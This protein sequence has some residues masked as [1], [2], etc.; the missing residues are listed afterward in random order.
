M[1][2]NESL[3]LVKIGLTMLD[4][5]G[6]VPWEAFLDNYMVVPRYLLLKAKKKGK[7]TQSLDNWLEGIEPVKPLLDFCHQEHERLMMHLEEHHPDGMISSNQFVQEIEALKGPPVELDYLMAL[8][9]TCDMDPDEEAPFDYNN[10]MGNICL[11]DMQ[12]LRNDE[13]GLENPEMYGKAVV[14]SNAD[15]VAEAMKKLKQ[16][17]ADHD[18]AILHMCKTEF[19]VNGDGFISRA[20][21]R[22]LVAKCRMDLTSWECNA[23]VN[24]IDLNGDGHLPYE[25]ILALGDGVPK[26]PKPEPVEGEEE[27]EEGAGAK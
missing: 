8:F 3:Y 26:T 13:K 19:D 12:R 27:G 14:S 23:L 22:R 20:E 25:E 10:F 16:Y 9:V 5:T 2:K 7:N 21:F 15:K 17:V 24:T 6:G 4:D 18:E 1:S 11:V